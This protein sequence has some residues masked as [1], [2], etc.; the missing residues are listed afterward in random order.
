MNNSKKS[1]TL[2]SLPY[3]LP[4]LDLEEP[5]FSNRPVRSKF[6]FVERDLERIRLVP[7]GDGMELASLPR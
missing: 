6:R 4:S 2:T 5:L 7:F 1:L 3:S